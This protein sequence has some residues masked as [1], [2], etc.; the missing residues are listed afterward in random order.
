MKDRSY[1]V[2]EIDRMRH[3]VEFKWLYGCRISA[4]H[5]GEAMTSHVHYAD[6]RTKAVE[7][8]L[9]TYMLAGIDPKELE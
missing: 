9:R 8:Q 2:A 3:A 1:T 7:E 5:M 4:R 6:E